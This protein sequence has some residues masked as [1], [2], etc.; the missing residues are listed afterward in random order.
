[1]VVKSIAMSFTETS[2]EHLTSLKFGVLEKLVTVTCFDK[3]QQ[4]TFREKDREPQLQLKK[5]T[6]GITAEEAIGFLGSKNIDSENNQCITCLYKANSIFEII[7]YEDEV[8]YINESM[9]N[10]SN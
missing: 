2:L 4:V 6:F 3:F 7:Y 8:Y 10:S 9:I 1:M 5:L